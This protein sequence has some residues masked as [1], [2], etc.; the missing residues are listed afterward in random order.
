MPTVITN[1]PFPMAMMMRTA[2]IAKLMS[3]TQ[4]SVVSL[5]IF[6][7]AC[8][9]GR[10]QTRSWIASPRHLV[11]GGLLRAELR[12]CDRLHVVAAGLA[13]PPA[14]FSLLP[15]ALGFLGEGPALI[16]PRADRRRRLFL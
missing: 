9:I 2:T 7:S 1:G 16:V 10:I 3:D 11:Q 15:I 6:Q 14:V 12:A 8:L 5:T 4:K 13:S